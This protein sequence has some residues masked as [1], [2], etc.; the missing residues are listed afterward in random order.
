MA[1]TPVNY[2]DLVPLIV[3]ALNGITV[4]GGVLKATANGNEVLVIAHN[5][6]GATPA[7]V[8]RWSVLVH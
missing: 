5:D 4:Q 8:S 1:R 3:T 6:S 2:T 7:H